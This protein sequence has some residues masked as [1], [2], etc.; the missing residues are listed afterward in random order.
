MHAPLA[1]KLHTEWRS[2]E[3]MAPLA[4]EWRALCV[5]AIEPN[6]FYDPDFA[7]PAAR[8]FG[9]G[10]GAMLVWSASGRLVGLFPGRI[11]RGHAGAQLALAG[12]THPYAPLGVPLVDRAEAEAVIAAWLDQISQQSGLLALAYLPEQGPFA[13]AL[14]AVL[15]NTNRQQAKFGGHERALLEAG[16]ERSGYLDRTV[17]SGKR[18]EIRRQRRRLEEMAPVTFMTTHQASFAEAALKDF[19]VLEASGW[20]GL[21]G[22][23]AAN[24]PSIRAFVESAVTAL[25]ARG[26]ARIDRMFLNGQPIAASITLS[27]GDTAWC[28]KIAYSEGVARYSPGVQLVFEL[29]E[30]LLADARVARTDS[31]AT[32]GHPM[33]DHVWRERLAV[34]DR[35][36]ELKPQTIPFG[37]TCKLEE[38]RRAAL[39]KAKAMRDSVRP[40]KSAPVP[41]Q[42]TDDL[43]GCRHRHLVDKSD[44]A[45]VLMRR[46]AGANEAL[47]V[48][49]QRI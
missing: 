24:D 45:R 20:K 4:D 38:L 39:A 5:R 28:W 13:R 16:S 43:A 17:S 26:Q 25:A 14:D 8:V 42:T 6:V 15:A 1:L 47:D 30:S 3:K 37:W 32:A 49:R 7:L 31:C 34:S 2:F 40:A 11:E 12:W 9:T 27:S 41:K 22:T 35:L 48:S 10:A 18:K 21:A 44:L 33:I 19:L 36:I 29:T 23:A 46:Q